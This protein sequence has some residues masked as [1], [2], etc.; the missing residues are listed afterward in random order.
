[1]NQPDILII[2]VI[3]NTYPETLRYL[4]SLAQVETSNITLILVD[5]SNQAK[6]PDFQQNI[7]K[8]RFLRYLE[9]GRNLGYFG[10]ARLGL[11]HYLTNHPAVPQWVL[12]TNVD[13]VFTPL[14][15]QQLNKFNPQKKLGVVAPSIISKKWNADY[16]PKISNR[17]PVSKLR[18]Y[19]FLYSCFLL[20]NLFLIAAYT[21]KWILGRQREK[22]NPMKNNPQGTKKIYAPHG[23]CM[24][25]TH[26]YFDLGGTLD[27]PH[28]LFGEEVFVAETAARLC[29]DVI[30][31]PE[32][33]VFDYEHASTGFFVT[34]EINRYNRQAIQS[35]RNR[36][37]P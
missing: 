7:K 30:Y 17:Y 29:L 11:T 21:K 16:N 9:S 5:N 10:G 8:F 36:F 25:F 32:M 6:P 14:F 4:D 27:L 12:V 31:D 23:S 1:M 26:T 15:F 20:H 13:I 2:G 22:N 35:I 34:P 19:Q 3:Y 37:Y 33:V 24:V 18:F 28:F